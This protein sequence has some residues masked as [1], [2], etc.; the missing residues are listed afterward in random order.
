MKVILR[1]IFLKTVDSGCT[2]NITPY[3]PT[4]PSNTNCRISSSC[5]GISCCTDV[6]TIGR[7]LQ[8][9]IDIDACTHTLTLAI[10]DFRFKISLID[11]KF[12]VEQ[13]FTI[14][15][16]FSLEYGSLFIIFID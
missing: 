6:S 1:F 5:T 14:D 13:K 10:E 9:S 2:E 16:V 8:Y 12:G 3:L 11:F 15:Q 7:T 4:L